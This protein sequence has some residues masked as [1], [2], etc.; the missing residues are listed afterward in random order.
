MD[1]DLINCKHNKHFICEADEC[2]TYEKDDASTRK[3]I[4]VRGRIVKAERAS[5]RIKVF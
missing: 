4:K 5:N 2:K 1:C 3:I